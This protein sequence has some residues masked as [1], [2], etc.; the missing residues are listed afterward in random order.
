MTYNE[1]AQNLYQ[2]LVGCSSFSKLQRIA[3]QLSELIH[4]YKDKKV[5][6]EFILSL[7]Y[8]MRNAIWDS[9][10]LDDNIWHTGLPT[11]NG[12]YLVECDG[13]IP[14]NFEIL[15]FDDGKFYKRKITNGGWGRVPSIEYFKVSNRIKRWRNIE[16]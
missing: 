2:E 7:L 10:D 14:N 11:E 12:R 15:I 9:K 13:I 1:R 4:C 16:E 5:G 8:A 3:S 6:D